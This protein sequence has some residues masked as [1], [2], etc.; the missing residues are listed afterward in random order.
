M[1]IFLLLAGWDEEIAEKNFVESCFG[2]LD[3]KSFENKHA[4]YFVSIILDSI[5]SLASHRPL[6]NTKSS[7]QVISVQRKNFKTIPSFH[8]P[9]TVTTQFGPWLSLS[10]VQ[11]RFLRLQRL[12]TVGDEAWISS[13]M[14]IG[15]CQASSL[16]NWDPSILKVSR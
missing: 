15:T 11:R 8:M 9:P 10:T 16:M 7:W 4:E 2:K 5:A 14:T 12:Q 1:P 6:P 3:I 13:L